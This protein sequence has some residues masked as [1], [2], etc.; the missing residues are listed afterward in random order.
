M[1]NSIEYKWP[2]CFVE[3]DIN[4]GKINL[5]SFNINYEIF[6]NKFL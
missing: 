4:I 5:L 1:Y 6:F 2:G 3:M